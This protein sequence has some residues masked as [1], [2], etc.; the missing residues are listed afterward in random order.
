MKTCG[1][2]TINTVTDGI[3]DSINVYN[4]FLKISVLIL[5]SIVSLCDPPPPSGDELSSAAMTSWVMIPSHSTPLLHCLAWL[6]AHADQTRAPEG[7]AWRGPRGRKARKQGIKAGRQAQEESACNV[8]CPGTPHGWKMDAEWMN[9]DNKRW[10]TWWMNDLIRPSRGEGGSCGW[11]VDVGSD[12][13]GLGSGRIGT[14]SGWGWRA[15]I[16]RPG[17]WL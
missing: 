5:L 6:P 11:L 4:L 10:M 8:V 12:R 9:L 7:G 1:L 3:L 15:G 14:G 16:D 2:K 17:L 13:V